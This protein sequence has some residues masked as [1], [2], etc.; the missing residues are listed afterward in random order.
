[1]G[2]RLK[3]T[4]LASAVLAWVVSLPAAAA[5]MSLDEFLLSVRESNPVLQ[6]SF[7]RLEAF[8]HTVRSS[9]AAR[10]ISITLRTKFQKESPILRSPHDYRSCLVC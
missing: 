3:A 8:S 7:R 10:P 2:K 9:V 1:M 6:A 5:E 4:I